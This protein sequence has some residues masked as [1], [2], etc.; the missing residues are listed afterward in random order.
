VL[1]ECEHT[2]NVDFLYLRPIPLQLGYGKIFSNPVAEIRIALM[3]DRAL[4]KLPFV[5]EE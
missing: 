3:V 1:G 5:G 4:D 2:F